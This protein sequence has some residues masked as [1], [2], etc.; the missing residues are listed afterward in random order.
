MNNKKNRWGYFLI[1]SYIL[2]NTSWAQSVGT[3]ELVAET[4]KPKLESSS[5]TK[6]SASYWSMFTGPAIGQSMN[7]SM[8]GDGTM[9]ETGAN[10]FQAAFIN[11]SFNSNQVVGAQLRA[12]S[13]MQAP[14]DASAVDFLNPR[15][16][17]HQKKVV[18]NRWFSLGLQPFVEIPTQAVSKQNTLLTT[19]LFAQNFTFKVPDE[20]WTLLLTSMV[21]QH[22]YRNSFGDKRMTDIIVF[23]TVGFQ[24][25]KTFQVLGWAWFDWTRRSASATDETN[26]STNPA[27]FDTWADNYA[28]VGMNI[29]VLDN[30]QIMPCAQFYTDQLRADNTTLGFEVSAN[31]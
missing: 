4:E 28:R 29:Y 19:L 16:F 1:I 30:L 12:S 8:T 27:G 17:F 9:T 6:F 23:P 13:D 11:Y 26:S 18:D 14:S 7:Q 31:F 5:P 21:N 22:F 15:I 20:R 3:S 10:Y 25:N 2:G 24:I